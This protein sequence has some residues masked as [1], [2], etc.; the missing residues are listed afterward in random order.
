M[1]RVK[2]LGTDSNKFYMLAV[3]LNGAADM[4]EKAA[5]HIAHILG[6]KDYRT[7]QRRLKNPEKLTLAQA[8]ILGRN[9]NIPIDALREAAIKY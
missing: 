9:L 8:S 6:F 4:D 5:T 1:P 2:P 7:A 3:L